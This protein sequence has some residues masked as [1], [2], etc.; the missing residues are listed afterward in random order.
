M[1]RLRELQVYRLVDDTFS[2]SLLEM[3]KRNRDEANL[4]FQKKTVCEGKLLYF[5]IR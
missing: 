3:G 2:I 4:K 1:T 5:L